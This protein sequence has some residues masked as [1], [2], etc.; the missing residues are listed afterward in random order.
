M[1]AG[2]SFEA[3]WVVKNTGMRPWNTRFYF[4]KV[5][6]DLGY[7]GTIFLAS[8]VAEGSEY[9]LHISMTAPTSAGS[10]NGTYKLVNDD[11]VAICQFF[12]AISVK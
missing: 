4:T 9:T 8:P 6:G 2:S 1:S 11:G 10:Y 5:K 12:V 7:S 3:Y